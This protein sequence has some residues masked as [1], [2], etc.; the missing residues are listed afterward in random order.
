MEAARIVQLPARIGPV[1]RVEG[2]RLVV[3][4]LSL[5]DHSLADFVRQREA[6]DRP[7]LVERALRIG[8]I[9]LQDAGL[10]LDVD[11]VR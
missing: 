11:V 5:S 9:A 1:V 10:T 8:L 7:A 6:V 3:E 4:N 2:D